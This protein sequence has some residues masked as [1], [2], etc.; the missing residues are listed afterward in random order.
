MALRRM[1][2]V[3]ESAAATYVSGMLMAS[4]ACSPF[5]LASLPDPGGARLP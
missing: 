4:F 5:P 3:A 1:V 2:R